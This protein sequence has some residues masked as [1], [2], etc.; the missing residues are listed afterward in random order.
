MQLRHQAI[1][2]SALLFTCRYRVCSLWK[3]AYKPLWA[4]YCYLYALYRACPLCKFAIKSLWALHYYLFDLYRAH[5][6]KANKLIGYQTIISFFCYLCGPRERTSKVHYQAIMS[7][8]LLFHMPF[9]ENVPH[10]KSLSGYS[11]LGVYKN[12]VL[13]VHFLNANSLSSH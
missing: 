7:S 3:F 13:T 11:E 6:I 8:F 9:T 5:S 10:A 1:M 4:M 2:K 12:M